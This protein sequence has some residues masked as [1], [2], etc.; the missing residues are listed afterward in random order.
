MI[1]IPNSTEAW[2]AVQVVSSDANSVM[3]KRKNSAQ[4]VKVSGNIATFSSVTM[5][6]LEENCDNLVDLESYNEG[7][8]IHNIRKRFAVDNIYTLVGN[9]LIAL[10]PYKPLDI[11]SPAIIDR[12]YNRVKNNEDLAPHIFT[13]A[14]T[15]V[16]NMKQDRK[17]QSVLI[18]GESGAG[19]TEATKKILVKILLTVAFFFK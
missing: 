3:V 6:A 17:N 5:Q 9:I 2:E 12:I 14:A 8:I 4:E 19:K 16:N 15:A 18:S 11:Y 10:N 1:W 7:I 13:I